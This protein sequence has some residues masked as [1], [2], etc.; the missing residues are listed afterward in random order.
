MAD[1]LRPDGKPFVTDERNAVPR[2]VVERDKD[3]RVILL[4]QFTGAFE[5]VGD[6]TRPYSKDALRV[7]FLSLREQ[8]VAIWLEPKDVTDDS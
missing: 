3:N 4:N 8:E 5:L 2:Y 7:A 6:G 1:M